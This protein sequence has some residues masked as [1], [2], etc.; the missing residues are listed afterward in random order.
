MCEHR[1]LQT[2][3]W[4]RTGDSVGLEVLVDVNLDAGVR[5]RVRAR[6]ADGSRLLVATT[7]DLELSALHLHKGRREHVSGAIL[8]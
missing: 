2:N 3:A 6:E 4:K 8:G 1:Q 5:A 7:G